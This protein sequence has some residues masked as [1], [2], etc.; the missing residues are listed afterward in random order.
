MCCLFFLL[1]E[2]LKKTCQLSALPP[3]ILCPGGLASLFLS[4]G[5]SDS[6]LQNL[7]TQLTKFPLAS[8][9]HASPVLQTSY[10]F[11]VHIRQTHPLWLYLSPL[12]P[13]EPLCEGKHHTNLVQK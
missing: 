1:W 11:V 5:D 7:S 6:E 12:N 2:I 10:S 8:C 13:D 4:C 3:A 9:Y